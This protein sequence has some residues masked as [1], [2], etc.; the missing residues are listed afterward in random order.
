MQRKKTMKNPSRT[1]LST[2]GTHPRQWPRPRQDPENA[3]RKGAR[4]TP[5]RFRCHRQSQAQTQDWSWT[6]CK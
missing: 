6:G 1:M 4:R 2:A 3:L 5:E